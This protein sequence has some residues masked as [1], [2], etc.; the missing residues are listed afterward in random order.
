MVLVSCAAGFLD[1]WMAVAPNK[2]SPF[3]LI[4]AFLLAVLIYKWCR[5]YA[6][7]R[8]VEPPFGASVFAAF[9]APIGIPL[10]FFRLLP[11]L[12]AS[13]ASLK[14]VSFFIV[15]LCIYSLAFYVAKLLTV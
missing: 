3:A 13:W 8:G 12:K 15:T 4:Y 1:A 9:L 10:Y 7:E 6:E 11:A 5:A 14:A 2:P